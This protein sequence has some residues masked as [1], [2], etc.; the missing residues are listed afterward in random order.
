MIASVPANESTTSVVSSERCE[1]AAC[2]SEAQSL[3]ADVASLEVKTDNKD[4]TADAVIATSSF[5]DQQ[6]SQDNKSAPPVNTDPD[7][8]PPLYAS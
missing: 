2:R 6:Q 8:V 5:P 3:R 1:A 4:V 7:S